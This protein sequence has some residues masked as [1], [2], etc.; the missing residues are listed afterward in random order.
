MQC[1]RVRNT[2]FPGNLLLQQNITRSC[3]HL[4]GRVALLGT[5]TLLLCRK[6]LKF[7]W[8]ATLNIMQ[9]LPGWYEIFF[10]CEAKFILIFKVP[11]IPLVVLLVSDSIGLD[12]GW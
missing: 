12:S 3:H 7:S 2:I 8:K 4:S 6:K 10:F 11:A 9:E 1:T 5:L